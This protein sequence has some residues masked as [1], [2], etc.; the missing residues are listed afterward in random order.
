MEDPRKKINPTMDGG[1]SAQTRD[2]STHL[3][4]MGIEWRRTL[5]RDHEARPKRDL[6]LHRRGNP[7]SP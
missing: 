2:G 6:H 3:K 1:T 4:M 7:R 5:H